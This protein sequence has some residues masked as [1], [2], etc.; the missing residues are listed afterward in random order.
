MSEL[1]RSI[2]L[3]GGARF[4]GLVAGMLTLIVTARALG[5]EG[6]GQVAAALTWAAL[7]S[8]VGYL[9]LGQVALHSAGRGR[10]ASWLARHLGSLGLVTLVVSVVGWVISAVSYAVTDGDLYG[11]LAVGVLALGMV[12]LPLL[13]WEQYGSSL[14]M[15]VDR[16]PVYNR[17]QVIGRTVGVALAVVLVIGLGWGVS[18][19]LLAI[20]VAQ[21]VV[22]GAGVK[23][24]WVLAG[25]RVLAN[26]ATTR[27]LLVGGAKLHLNAVGTFLF[28]SVSVLIVQYYRGAEETGLFQLAVQLVAVLLVVP[29]AAAM[30]LYSEVARDGVDRAWPATMRVLIRLTVAMAALVAVAA[31]VAP[32]VIPFV[33]GE[34]FRPAVPVFQLL[35]VAVVGQTFSTVM[36]PQWIGRGLFWQVSAASLATGVVTVVACLYLVPRHG[37]IGA[38]WATVGV[39]VLSVFGNGAFGV[40]VH[41]RVRA[42]ALLPEATPGGRV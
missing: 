4:Y 19:A 29:Q 15:A 9:S 31:L 42:A 14:L 30:V 6:R 10:D 13:I 34:D 18:G 12:A 25:R 16:L 21:A 5:P 40:W 8:S 39:Y 7:F 23:V 36:A 17:A 1:W 3:A 27:G 22:A 20:L 38:A 11:G 24:L 32:W 28:T 37:M 33:V 41:R 2:V 35:L 26:R